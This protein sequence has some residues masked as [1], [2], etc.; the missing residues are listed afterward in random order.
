MSKG[1]VVLLSLYVVLALLAL[2]MPGT[3]AGVWSLRLLLLLAVVH[4]IEVAVFFKACKAAG[5]SLPL[6][7]L[8]VFLFGV[9]HVQEIRE[10]A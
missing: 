7:L 6:H 9:I 8:N 4:A 10:A 1:K 5:G 3:S 2:A